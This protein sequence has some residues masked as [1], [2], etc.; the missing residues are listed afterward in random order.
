MSVK[1]TLLRLALMSAT[2]FISACGAGS[3]PTM[4]TGTGGSVP[5]PGTSTPTPAPAT[6]PPA[7]QSYG[8]DR[9]SPAGNPTIG[10]ARQGAYQGQQLPEGWGVYSTE[11]QVTAAIQKIYAAQGD[12]PCFQSFYPG[13]TAVF[14]RK[15]R[16]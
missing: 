15:G 12:W 7:V 13:A 10:T 6:T 3:L 9:E 16:L 1:T 8:C 2:G 11:S 4:S 5:M 14:K